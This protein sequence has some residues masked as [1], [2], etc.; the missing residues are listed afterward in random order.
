MASPYVLVVYD[1]VLFE[2]GH[3]INRWASSVARTFEAHAIEYAPV[4]VRPNKSPG[5]PPVGTL[6]ASIF[7]DVDLVGPK[8]DPV[9]A[10]SDAPYAQYVI[11][12]TGFIYPH[13]P[14]LKLPS[15]PG[16]GRRTRFNVVPGQKANNFLGKAARATARRHPSLR[17]FESM[18]FEQT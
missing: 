2:R 11:E 8:H 5:E 1:S 3:M 7:A 16:R 10:G 6:K 12:G 18:L 14:F 9:I 15:N 13:G 17:G 4:N